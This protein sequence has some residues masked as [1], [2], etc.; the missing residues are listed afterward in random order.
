MHAPGG[1]DLADFPDS[2]AGPIGNR[3][4]NELKIG[5]N[6]NPDS[7]LPAGG[8]IRTRRRRGS[9]K[10]PVFSPANLRALQWS[11]KFN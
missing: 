11:L 6:L 3:D 2:D 9:G 4:F 10:S 5:G 1:L 8:Q 7:P